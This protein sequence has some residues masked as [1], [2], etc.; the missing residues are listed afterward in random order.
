MR[1]HSMISCLCMTYNRCPDHQRLLEEAIESFLRQD[2]KDKELLVCND[3]PG[4]HLE[5]SHPQVRIFNF[6]ERMPTLTDKIQSMIDIARG[7]I[8]CR[9]DDDDISL[10]HRL[11][12]S[13]DK[14]GDGLEWRAANYIYSA[15]DDFREVH[16]PGNTH[17]FGLFTRKVLEKIG[18]YPSKVSGCEDMRF[19]DRL[20]EQGLG[21]RQGEPIP[22]E[23][24]YYFYRWGVSPTHLSGHGDG[25][26]GNIHQNHYDRIGQRPAA[27][28]EIHLHPHWNRDYSRDLVNRYQI[29]IERKRKMAKPSEM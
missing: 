24:M 14:L 15:P 25:P 27:V 26:Q 3:T 17:V 9:W 2:Y 6:P 4:Q 18:G 13:R 19:V 29:M 12:Y 16:N 20:I 5:F 21:V 7:D 22:S 23:D 11:S 28:G 10:P 8:L 1:D